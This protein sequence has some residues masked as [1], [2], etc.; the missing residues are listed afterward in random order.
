MLLTSIVSAFSTP[1]YVT[2]AQTESND[3]KLG[4]ST[5]ERVSDPLKVPY[6]DHT[7]PK[8]YRYLKQPCI[9]KR[10]IAIYA[11]YR[12]SSRTAQKSLHSSKSDSQSFLC[13]RHGNVQ[14]PESCRTLHN[15][16]Q[17]HR[18]QDYK[19]IGVQA[20]FKTSSCSTTSCVSYIY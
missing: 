2:A 10:P 14:N 4:S 8:D 13:S 18:E 15:S 16:G 11:A 17:P 3:S 7:S 5:S 9:K 1:I 20:R 19:W 6:R 12:T